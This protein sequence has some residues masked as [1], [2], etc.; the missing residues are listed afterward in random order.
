VLEL[1]ELSFHF[2]SLYFTFIALIDAGLS[3]PPR[4]QSKAC[5]ESLQWVKLGSSVESLQQLVKLR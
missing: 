4:N 1:T 2:S 3:Y 5:N